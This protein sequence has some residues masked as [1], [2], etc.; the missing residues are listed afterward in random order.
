MSHWLRLS[1]AILCVFAI[2]P[3][4]LGRSYALYHDSTT[5]RGTAVVL[6]NLD[7]H[8]VT[9]GLFAYDSAGSEIVSQDLTLTRFASEAVFLDELIDVPSGTTW[10]LVR[11]ETIGQ[12]ALAAWMRSEETWFAVENVS[13]SMQAV[14][15]FQYSGY[16]LTAN[17]ANTPNRTTG[18]S[19]VNPYDDRT[20]GAIYFYDAEGNRSAAR[21]FELGPRMAAFILLSDELKVAETSWGLL[22]VRS[23]VPILLVTEYFDANGE[24]IDLDMVSSFYF[25]EP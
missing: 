19:L 10:G 11:A 23:D 1:V 12:I 7:E 13:V 6:T 9:L 22:D 25:V 21:P 8:D 18:V 15:E 16:W 14:D 2:A 3:S 20:G 5:G 17:Y 4:A 24:S